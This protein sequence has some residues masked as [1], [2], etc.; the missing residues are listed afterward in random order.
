MKET[1]KTGIYSLLY[2]V[3]ILLSVVGILIMV[4]TGING[5]LVALQLFRLPHATQTGFGLLFSMNGLRRVGP[6]I[7]LLI[8]VGALEV[9][10]WRPRIYLRRYAEM[11]KDGMSRKY[12]SYDRLSAK[13]KAKIDKQKLLDMERTLN[14]ATLR[15]LTYKGSRTPMEDM[16]KLIGLANVKKSM[17]TMVARMQY[18]RDFRGDKKRKNNSSI[19]SRHMCFFGPP[20]T[21]K[22]T[23]ARVMA[24]FLYQY[25]YIRKNQCV[26]VDG[27]FLKGASPGETAAKTSLLIQKSLGGV[28]FIDEAYSLLELQGD[29]YG[30]EAIATIVKEMEDNKDNLIIILAGYEKEMKE[31][32]SSNPGIQSRIREYLYF[33]NYSVYELGQ[34]FNLMANQENF[35]V[36]HKALE[37]FEFMIA[38]DVGD[39]NFGNARTV[40]N[41]VDKVIDKHAY[42]L[43]EGIIGQD[44]AYTIC[45]EDIDFQ[46]SDYL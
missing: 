46:T 5:I 41:Y 42:N 25:K 32:I 1:I 33:K 36:S 43:I 27:N 12:S 38:K 30:Q 16:N 9:F 37:R 44:L 40:R 15:Q 4:Y 20:G 26:E 13:D 24:G 45:P 19:S 18:E 34:I 8:M 35:Y 6:Y 23:V 39:Q 17:K 21:G 2:Y 3:V 29:R 22:T 28:L 14:S 7:L 10:L 11:T 31:L